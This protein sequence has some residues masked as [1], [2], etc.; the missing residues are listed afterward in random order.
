MK[1][2]AN[3]FRFSARELSELEPSSQKN[4]ILYHDELVNSL[5]LRISA[6]GTITFFVQKRSPYKRVIKSTIGRYP[7]I[8]IPRAREIA[9]KKLS[10]IAEGLIFNF[11]SSR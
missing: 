4:P 8:S 10:L 2:S 5:S 7:D 3:T 9:L 11:P 6:L 1:K